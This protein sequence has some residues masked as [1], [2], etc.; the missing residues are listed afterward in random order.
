MSLFPRRTDV[1]LLIFC[2]EAFKVASPLRH[3]SV[4]CSV[5]VLVE[6]DFGAPLSLQWL[7]DVSTVAII[8]LL[9]AAEKC[10]LFGTD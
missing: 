10:W 2:R 7:E 9:V 6:I 1:L 4:Y 5:I 3:I 8:L